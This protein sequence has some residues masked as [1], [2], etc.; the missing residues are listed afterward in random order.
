MRAPRMT[1]EE[2]ERELARLRRQ[3]EAS[4]AETWKLSDKIEALEN[5]LKR[6]KAK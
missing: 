4:Q 6:R 1:I 5:R 3:H 2:L